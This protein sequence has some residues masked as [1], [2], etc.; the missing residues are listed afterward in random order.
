M[1]NET[2]R[3]AWVEID[4][5]AMNYNYRALH[6]LA[7]DSAVIAAVKADAYGHN[8]VKT[9]WEFVKAGVEYLGVAT[10][11]EAVE[12]RQAGIRTPVVLLGATPRGNLKDILDL[13]VIP[14]I[15]SYEDAA[16]LSRTAVSFA[17]GKAV[18]LFLAVETGMGRLGLLCDEKGL[19]AAADIARL[20]GVNLLG[21]FS[22]FAAADDDDP[23]FTLGQI[24]RF[25]GI[26]N[27]LADRGIHPEIRTIANSAGIMRYPQA[28]YEAV[29]PGI[30]LYGLYPAPN[31]DDGTTGLKPVMSV[32]ANIVLLRKVPAGFPVSYGHRFITRR[33]SLIGVLPLGYGDGL[34]RVLSGKGRVIVNGVYAPLVGAVTMDQTMVDLTDVP[35]VKEYDEAVILGSDGT[36]SIT[37]DEIAGLADTISYE[38]TTRF[39]QRLPKVYR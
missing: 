17:G 4:I 32:H 3:A 12:L 7:P 37:A 33:E 21:L 19:S 34:P 38:V 30:S 5:G 16:L 18:D 10:L 20:P 2:R 23:A 36:L 9:S 14:V 13:K 35:G 1:Y 28:H 39:G 22:H 8:A 26:V 27:A 31:M 24:E 25:D 15:S 29:R 6:D 11:G